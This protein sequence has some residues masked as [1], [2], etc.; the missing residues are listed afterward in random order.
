M[1]ITKS[2]KALGQGLAYYP[3]LSRF[4]KSVKISIFYNQLL[5]WS[6]RTDDPLGVYKSA[7]EWEE[8][9]GLSYREQATAR[10]ALVKWGFMVE[11]HKRLQHRIY[12]CLIEDAIDAAWEVWEATG[13]SPN[14]ENAIGEKRTA[15]PGKNTRRKR[16][17]PND[18]SAIGGQHK[19]QVGNKTMTTAMTTASSPEAPAEQPGTEVVVVPV[20]PQAPE[21]TPEETAHQTAC[22]E[23]WGAYRDAY[24]QRYGA[25]PVRNAKMSSQIKQF[26]IRI[27]Q[28]DAPGV[29]RFFVERV[30]DRFVLQSFHAVGLLLTNAEGYRTQW[31]TNRTITAT[32]AQQADKTAANFNAVDEAMAIMEQRD[33]QRE[34]QH[35]GR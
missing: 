28:Q 16:N 12:F 24:S 9:T 26:V 21:M 31:A 11:T 17:P 13:K 19:A 30:N 33:R 10:A 35:A 3:K 7:E 2:G 4:F 27:G 14:D 22:R 20:K 29:A 8:E 1:G 34:A 6:T 15:Q 25:A 32:Q 5:Y 18:E 23:T